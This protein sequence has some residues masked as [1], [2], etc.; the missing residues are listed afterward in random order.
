MTVVSFTW[1]TAINLVPALVHRDR[2]GYPC[3]VVL[4]GGYYQH[5]KKKEF[6]LLLRPPKGLELLAI[7]FRHLLYSKCVLSLCISQQFVFSSYPS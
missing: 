6:A 5:N 3:D 7:K 4:R 1:R 2:I